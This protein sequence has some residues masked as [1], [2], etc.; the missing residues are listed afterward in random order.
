MA[1]AGSGGSWLEFYGER[2]TPP[3][4]PVGILVWSWAEFATLVVRDLLRARVE[5]NKLVLDPLLEG[6]TVNV[7][8]RDTM[9]AHTS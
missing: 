5:N 2:P 6:L 3:L 7:R 4:P 1:R 9:I 8:F